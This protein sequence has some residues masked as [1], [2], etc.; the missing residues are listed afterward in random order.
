ME[1]VP[2][3]SAED[4]RSY[5]KRVLARDTVKI[6]VVGDIDAATLGTML[7]RVFGTLPAKADLQPIA[8]I[9]AQVPPA[10]VNVTLDVPQTVVLFGAPD[11]PTSQA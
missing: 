8:P 3:I 10:R 4:I 9:K 11:N 6:S 5:V 2:K 7:D 1:S